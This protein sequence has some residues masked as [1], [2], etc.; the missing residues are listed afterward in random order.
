MAYEIFGQDPE[1]FLEALG[2]IRRRIKS[3]HVT[4]LVN[5]V[6]TVQQQF[7]SLLQ[8]YQSDKVIRRHMQQ[9]FDSPVQ[10]GTAHRHIPRNVVHREILFGYIAVYNVRQPIQKQLVRFIQT[11]RIYGKTRSDERG[12]PEQRPIFQYRGNLRHQVIDPKKVSQCMRPH[13]L[14]TRLFWMPCPT[15]PTT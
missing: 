12:F 13:R 3:G 6:F 7:G 2:K 15:W 14:P 10:I 11:V 8:L 1:L 4:N 5:P 9:A